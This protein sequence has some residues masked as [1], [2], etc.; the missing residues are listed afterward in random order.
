M[1]RPA[2]QRAS[3]ASV[4][5]FWPFRPLTDTCSHD[6]KQSFGKTLWNFFIRENNTID[7]VFIESFHMNI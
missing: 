2:G 3:G 1:A 7:M 5:G 4:E 6:H